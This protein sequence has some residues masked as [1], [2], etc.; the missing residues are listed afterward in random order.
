[1]IFTQFC[2]LMLKFNALVYTLTNRKFWNNLKFQKFFNFDNIFEFF[3]LNSQVIWCKK[4]ISM[5]SNDLV[6]KWNAVIK[7]NSN[8]K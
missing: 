1:M 5:S 3:S 6:I 4:L 2:F 8:S 7:L